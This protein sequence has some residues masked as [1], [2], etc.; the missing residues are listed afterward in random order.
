MASDPEGLG[1]EADKRWRQYA[2]D[3]LEKWQQM[4]RHAASRGQT[5]LEV[6]RKSG[7][8]AVGGAA[9]FPAAVISLLGDLFLQPD[10]D[11]SLVT[12]ALIGIV[13]LGWL[14][15]VSSW[16][17]WFGL[18][19]SAL[20]SDESGSAYAKE[21]QGQLGQLLNVSPVTWREILRVDSDGGVQYPEPKPSYRRCIIISW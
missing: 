15:Y 20:G 3:D 13:A 21:L 9:F 7:F 14:V 11:V 10:S 2:R 17:R 4:I 16:L 1:V 6:R 12:I 5:L 19:A 8:V 18:R